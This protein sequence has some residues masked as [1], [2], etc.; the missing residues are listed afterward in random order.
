MEFPLRA[1]DGEFRWFLTRVKPLHNAQGEIVRWFGSNANIDERR[2]NDDFRET[3]LGVVG[4]DLRSPLNTVLM[5]SEMLTSLPDTPMNIRK[6]LERVTSSGIRMQRMIEQLLDFT[7]GRLTTGIP[8]TLSAD[9][10]DL[11]AIVAK[12]VDEVRA[13]HPDCCVELDVQGDCRA[14]I[15]PD[16]FE[17]VVSNLL[18]NAV[19]HGDTTKPVD[20]GLTSRLDRVTL[21]VRNH[22]SPISPEFL[23]TLFSPFAREQKTGG[24]SAGLGLGL[25]ISERIV[26]G[27][28]GTFSVTSSEA[29][30]TRFEV[31]LPRRP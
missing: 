22:G 17:Q 23:P 29:D 8:I 16:R 21:T 27:H 12:I 20:V 10:S 13:G 2:R 6:M 4:H 9:D 30:G 19:A 14:R 26:T 31:S 11:Q 25:Y 7:R 28:R 3:F 15:D 5:T 1:A 18:G 24:P